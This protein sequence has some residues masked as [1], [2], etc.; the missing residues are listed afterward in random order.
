MEKGIWSRIWELGPLFFILLTACLSDGGDG[1]LTRE[2]RW[3]LASRICGRRLE[4]TF[5]VSRQRWAYRKFRI[6]RNASE[7]DLASCSRSCR[8]F[9]AMSGAFR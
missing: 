5:G 2:S 3:R 4:R 1:V 8:H 7:G 9:S 6:L